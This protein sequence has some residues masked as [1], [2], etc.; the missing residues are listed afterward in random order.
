MNDVLSGMIV[1]VVTAIVVAGIFLWAGRAKK[2]TI[3]ALRALCVQRGWQY[4][5][6]SGP[7]QRGHR[8]AGDGWAFEAASRSSGRE[9]APGSSDWGHS[10]QWIAAGEDPGRSTF[11]L[12]GR[13]AGM[14]GISLMPPA[15]LSR[16]LGEEAAG[17]Q[18]VDAGG[19]LAEKYVLLA[20]AGI[21]VGKLFP[22]RAQELLRLWP[23][24]LRLVVRSSPARLALQVADK[25]LEKPEDVLRL[26]ELGE[27]LAAR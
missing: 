25:R 12:G 26:I 23:A 6:E 22:A 24:G 10:S 17:L 4:K 2:R 1:A 8:I 19:P 14:I 13:P 16:F 7:L 18:P 21:G 27:S 9:T 11:I 5:Y 15:V 20:P 3:E